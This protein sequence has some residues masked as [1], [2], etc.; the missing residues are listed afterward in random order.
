V[1]LGEV[2]EVSWGNT[3]ITKASYELEGFPA[4]SA[5]GADGHLP[6]YEYDREA[7]VLS[8]IGARCGKCFRAGGKWT[9]IKNTIV[10]FPKDKTD[11]DVDFLFFYLNRE[12]VWPTDAMAQPFITMGGAQSVLVPLPP[13][14][15]QRRIAGILKEQMAAV[16][17]ARAAAE[18]QLQA[19]KALPAAYLREVFPAPDAPLPKGWRWVKLGEVCELNPSRT[20][21]PAREDS[22]PT[23]FIPMSAVDEVE[24]IV[25]AME[26]RPYSEVKK[27]YTFFLENDILFA[28][29]TPCMQNGK[30]AIARNL[31]DG[32]GF[33][34]T[35]FHVI[36][37]L[38]SVFPEWI[39]F[40]VRQPV[41]LDAAKAHF[42]GAV[43]Q[44]RVP[45]NYL[46]T[47][48]IP[49]PPLP[50]QRRIAGILKEQMA[51]VEKARA[52][53]EA[54]LSEINALPSA[55]LRQAFS[56]LL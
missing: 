28:K 10:I 24:G 50:E 48:D 41:I 32:V 36:H 37:P 43:G 9:A 51:A 47:L 44:Q 16:E 17:K 55:L 11:S 6:S 25:R 29:I 20:R 14:P 31:I 33:G 26:T 15:E 49:L 38:E 45:E 52:A 3:S 27:G 56:G 54:Q 42:S 34:S 8:A 21:F 35:E 30:H 40:F 5:T 39:H 2:C 18:A 22:A 46:H 1:K 13:L 23:S 12:E 53:A 19:A 7:V 4:Y